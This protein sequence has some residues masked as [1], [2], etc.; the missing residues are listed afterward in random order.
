M[1]LQD[2]IEKLLSTD[3]NTTNELLTAILKELKQINQN[4]KQ[5]PK[6]ANKKSRNY[7]N[8]VN[9]LRDDLKPN[10]NKDI[11]PTINYNSREIAI[12][13]N[14]YLYDKKSNE[15]LKAYEAYKIY[16]FL[17]RNRDNLNEYITGIDTL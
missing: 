11:Y 2:E 15:N 5:T 17:Y 3:S 9:K 4:L 8:F 7:Y 1:K 12:T 16:D 10:P 14:G 13:S 6:T